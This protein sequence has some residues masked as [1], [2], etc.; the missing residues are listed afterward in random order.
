M[1]VQFV[2]VGPMKFMQV[3]VQVFRLEQIPAAEVWRISVTSGITAF[4][5]DLFHIL[6]VDLSSDITGGLR[7]VDR[8]S[9]CLIKASAISKAT[10]GK[11]SG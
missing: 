3:N 8:I 11:T 5:S 9:A 2:R 1:V 6:G 7:E 10:N 4:Y